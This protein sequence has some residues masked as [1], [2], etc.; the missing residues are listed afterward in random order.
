VSGTT[1]PDAAA[2]GERRYRRRLLRLLA[3]ATF[4]NGYDGF[5]LPFV[6]SLILVGLNG[7]EA[8]A[9]TVQLIA[10][11]GA[12]LAFFLA[13][14]ADRI[15]RRRLLLITITGY[16]IAVVGTALSVNLVMLTG[17]QFVAQVF[18]GAEWAVAITIVVEE[19]PSH[20]R[21]R[22]LSVLVAMLTLGAILVGL[23]G[24]LGL[25]STPLGW[26]AFYLVGIVPLIVVAI[27]RRG[28]RETERYAAVRESAAGAKLD[29]SS[30]LEPWKRPFRYNLL[31]VGLLHFFRYFA[32]SAAVFWW[33]YYAQQEVGMSLSLSGIYLAVAGVLGAA[34]FLVAGRST[35]RWGRRPT[36]L[37]YTAASAVFGVWLFQT[38]NV[39]LMLP[40]LCMGSGCMTSAFATEF[41]PTYVRSRAAAWCR[42]AFEIPGGMLGPF[43]VGILGDHTTGPLGSIGSAMTAVFIATL[44][45]V[46]LIAWLY[47]GETK[48]VDLEALDAALEWQA[49]V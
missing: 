15:G 10:Q 13:A 26:R 39:A 5:V 32:V 28:M 1:P 16:T 41:F 20:D 22:S 19:F 21:G 31:A 6:L 34:G 25:G 27:A 23:L 45:P 43:L 11:S 44:L 38:R 42:N 14:Q 49:A 17:A 8:E 29:R 18:L 3:T 24:F 48:G 12:V 33:P 46:L 7:T 9:G 40:L 35:E 30:L 37:V 4:F 47:V 2:G 36:F